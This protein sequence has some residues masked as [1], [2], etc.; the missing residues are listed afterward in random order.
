MI[1]SPPTAIKT[2]R[3]VVADDEGYIREYFSRILPRIGHQVVGIASN[4]R[5]LVK[6]CLSES[7]DLVIT[8]VRMPEMSGIEAADQISKLQNI[9]IIIVSSYDK[10]DTDNQNV[11]EFLVKPIDM[12]QLAVAIAKVAI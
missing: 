4:G 11:V 9:P 5:E 2:R 8:D 3:I 1:E 12:V 10:P 6:L 7:P